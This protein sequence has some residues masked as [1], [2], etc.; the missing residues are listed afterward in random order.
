MLGVEKAEVFRSHLIAIPF[1]LI[2]RKHNK[3]YVSSIIPQVGSG[4]VVCW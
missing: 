4:R 3:D 2:I 1:L